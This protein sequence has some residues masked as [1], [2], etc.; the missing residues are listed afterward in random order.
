MRPLA[1]KALFVLAVSAVLIGLNLAG[2][3]FDRSHP[4]QLLQVLFL[5]VATAAMTVPQVRIDQGR[6]TL[7]GLITGSTAILLNPL[8]ATI[9]SL[10][11]VVGSNRQRGP[12]PLVANSVIFASG[13]CFGAVTTALL[14]GQR[15]P[16]L[17]VRLAAIA[18]VS[19]TNVALASIAIATQESQSPIAVLRRNVTASFV[20]AF[21]YFGLASLLIS[22]VLDG[23]AL[24][25]LL[26]T[27]VCLLSLALTDSIAGR[28]IRSVLESELTDADRHLFHS[29]AVDGVVHNLRNHIATAHAYLKEIDPRKLDDVD[30]DNLATATGATEDAVSVLHTLAQGATPK[31]SYASNPVDLNE[32]AAQAAGLARARAR[33]KEIQIA[34]RESAAEVRVRADPLLIREVMTNLVNNAIDAAPQGGRVEIRTGRRNNNGWPYVAV[35]DN[36]PGVSDENR[37]HLF[38]PHYTTKEGGTGLGL[39]MSYGVVREHQGQLLFEGNRRGA[40]FTVI[41]PP[42]AG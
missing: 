35:G 33:A 20:V 10:A 39:F 17:L 6:L 5:A 28:R 16:Q 23:S 14:S 41:L 8:N 9:A 2:L 21:A 25:Y 15:Q 34:V 38:E 27:I 22:Y 19:I 24:G 31:V 11:V 3:S 18:V 29:R 42:F 26:A 4:D 7:N 12:W 40:V 37:H 30:R 1:G 32:L 36:G 13:S